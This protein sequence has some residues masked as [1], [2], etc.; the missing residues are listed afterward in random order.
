MTIG[1]ITVVCQIC[2]IYFCLQILLVCALLLQINFY[3]LSNMI[4]SIPYPTY[5]KKKNYYHIQ[6]SFLLLYIF[7][8]K[9]S[10]IYNSLLLIT[11]SHK[12]LVSN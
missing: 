10:S 4:I 2:A 11:I 9:F 7:S 8:C 3:N 1:N 6:V 12:K 5:Q